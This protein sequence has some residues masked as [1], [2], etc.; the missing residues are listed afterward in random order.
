MLKSVLSVG[1]VLTTLAILPARAADTMM[2]DEAG[3]M[4]MQTGVSGMTDATKKDMA[5]KEMSMAKESMAKKD[6]KDCMMH[7]EKVQGMM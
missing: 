1:V 3:M 2:C 6:E 7:M 4:K 5:M